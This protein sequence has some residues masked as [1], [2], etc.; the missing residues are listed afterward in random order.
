MSSHGQIKKIGFFQCRFRNTEFHWYEAIEEQALT[1][2]N[3]VFLN[4]SNLDSYSNKF[5]VVSRSSVVFVYYFCP[6]GPLLQPTAR[7]VAVVLVCVLA[8]SDYCY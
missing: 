1:T 7:L 6:F 8:L 5:F 2:L 4:N 3:L